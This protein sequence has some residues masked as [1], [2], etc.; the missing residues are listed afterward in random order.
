MKRPIALLLGIVVALLSTSVAS[1][2]PPALI[3]YWPLVEGS[4]QVVHDFSGY[5]NNG[6]LGSTSG[7]DVNDPTWIRTRFLPAL[8]FSGNQWVA[9]PNSSVLQPTTITVAALVRSG[10]SPGQ[11]TYIFSKGGFSCTAASYG[12]YTGF[13]GGLAFYI[14]NGSTF[15]LSPEAPP[16]VWD[17]R[18][19]SVAG[20]FDG[21]TIRLYVDGVQVGSGTP[22][23]L[24]IGYALDSLYP[25]IGAYRASC[26]LTFSGDI[27]QV[28]IWNQA[29]SPGSI[30]QV[31]LQ[32]LSR[33]Y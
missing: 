20:T 8:H 25:Y 19:H 2:A 7:V 9:I 24:A 17:G 22:T 31:A 1:A 28:N 32:A 21:A 26:D 30:W 12:L 6:Q 23:P 27:G 4:G 18:W 14:S 5:R 29:L 33:V 15:A 13:G 10:S 11:W 3:G 16:S